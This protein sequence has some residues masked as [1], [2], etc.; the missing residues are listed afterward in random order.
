MIMQH[1]DAVRA[2][3]KLLRE[4]GVQSFR[5]GGLEIHLAPV[6]VFDPAPKPDPS[7]MAREGDAERRYHDDIL[8]AAV[9]GA[10]PEE[11]KP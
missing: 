10:P 1:A 4:E 3:V 8:F 6:I 7:A 9:G 2:L 11:V 5:D